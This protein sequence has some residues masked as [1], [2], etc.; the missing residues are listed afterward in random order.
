[1]TECALVEQERTAEGLI[2]PMI[3][4]R[5]QL[6]GRPTTHLVGGLTGRVVK[7]SDLVNLQL[8][9]VE[10]LQVMEDIPAERIV[11][12]LIAFEKSADGDSQGNGH[13]V[14]SKEQVVTLEVYPGSMEDEDNI[15]D[16][17]GGVNG[18]NT[19]ETLDASS[20]TAVRATPFTPTTTNAASGAHSVG[21]GGVRVVMSF[22]C[23]LVLILQNSMF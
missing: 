18:T 22:S 12:D 7:W 19:T 21:D 9:Q 6:K 16:I 14:G 2:A 20:T 1:M 23:L 10:D 4:V 8:F 17:G 3:P 15:N 13:T 5:A 11:I